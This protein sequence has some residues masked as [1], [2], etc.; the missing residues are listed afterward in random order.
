MTA[1]L[2]GLWAR[3]GNVTDE[4]IRHMQARVEQFVALVTLREEDFVTVPPCKQSWCRWVLTESAAYAA[5]PGLHQPTL[6]PRQLPA[7]T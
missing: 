6:A 4:D 1:K 2:D 3:V 5:R 7:L